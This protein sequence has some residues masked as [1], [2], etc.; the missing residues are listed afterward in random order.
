MVTT[1]NGLPQFTNGWAITSSVDGMGPDA[2]FT[3]P[4]GLVADGTG[5]IFVTDGNHTIRKMTAVGTNWM[6]TTV[7]GQSGIHGTNDGT[8]TNAQFYY[9]SGIAMDKAGN[10][11]VT[12]VSNYTVR[13][14]T[15]MG[16]NWVVT[17][18]AGVPGAYG[19]DDG[20][21]S[22]ARFLVP[23]GIAADSV[24]DVY[25]TDYEYHTIR[26]GYIADGAPALMPSGPDFGF[27]AGAF[28]FNIA[29]PAGQS[30]LVEGSTDLMNWMP[31]WTNTIGTGALKFSD[32]ESGTYPGRFY[33]AHKQ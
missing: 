33:R 14:M 28:G 22:V 15:P 12:D 20:T 10:F 5:N 9:P 7:A 6:V 16:T 21:G 26:R 3:Y 2:R 24:G 30:V 19:S 11:F 27:N 1:L 25:V 13:K 31:V 32:S 29:G 8:G 4:Y 18:V 17:T 23:A